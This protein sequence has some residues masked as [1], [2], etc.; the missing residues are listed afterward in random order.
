M[1]EAIGM[2]R[3]ISHN[4]IPTIISAITKFI[5]GIC[6]T[7]QDDKQA[8]GD[9]NPQARRP[10]DFAAVHLAGFPATDLA[11]SRDH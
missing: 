10:C 2:K 7:P 9:P 1:L 4:P 11:G 6:F 3:L 8:L 5:K